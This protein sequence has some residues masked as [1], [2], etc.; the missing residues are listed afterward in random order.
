MS[1]VLYTGSTFKVRKEHLKCY[2]HMNE[3][4]ITHKEEAEKYI[5][6]ESKQ[7]PQ[8]IAGENERSLLKTSPKLAEQ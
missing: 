2:I 6:Q 3:L 8:A 4:S 1:S 5:L 7:D